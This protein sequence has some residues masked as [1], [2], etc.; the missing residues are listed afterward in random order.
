MNSFHARKPRS[1]AAP[2]SARAAEE[3]PLPRA[4]VSLVRQ[5]LAAS[6][7]EAERLINAGRVSSAG[8]VVTKPAQKFPADAE[9]VIADSS[10]NRYVSRGGLKLAGALAK[11]GLAVAGRICLDVGQSTGGFT[12]CLLQAGAAR[13]VGVDVG[14]GQ[15][16]QSLKADSR[17]TSFEGVNARTLANADLGEAMNAKGFDLIV[18]DVSFISLTLIM[19]RLPALLHADGDMLLLVKPQ[20]EVGPFGIGKGGIVTTPSLYA[21]VE[22]KLRASATAS[23]LTVLDWF[24]SPITGSD[25]NREFFIWTAHEH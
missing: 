8:R 9:F 21:E 20:F 23:R 22:R 6:R 1:A 16:H 25:G 4:D 2:K 19:P 13:V 12:D 15:L 7:A 5:G 18:A 14:H 10:D 3:S 24:E 17:I 11:S